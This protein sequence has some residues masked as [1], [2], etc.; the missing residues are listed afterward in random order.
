MLLH[1]LRTKG[2]SPQTPDCAGLVATLKPYQRKAL[3]WMAQREESGA[4]STALPSCMW[5]SRSSRTAMIGHIWVITFAA[6]LFDSCSSHA[7]WI[8]RHS[9]VPAPGWQSTANAFK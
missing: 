7:D 8:V 4:A 5:P 1:L 6:Q 2:K 9:R 3:A